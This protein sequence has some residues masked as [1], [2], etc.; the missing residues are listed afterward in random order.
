MNCLHALISQICPK[1]L[2]HQPPKIFL[3]YHSLAMCVLLYFC[4]AVEVYNAGM[5]AESL[6]TICPEYFYLRIVR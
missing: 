5:F 2:S 1:Q 3:R 4:A 6:A